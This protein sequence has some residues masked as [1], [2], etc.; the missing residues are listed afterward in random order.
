MFFRTSRPRITWHPE[1]ELQFT[2]CN[3][4]FKFPFISH[5]FDKKTNNV[6]KATTV[7]CKLFNCCLSLTSRF[8]CIL[9]LHAVLC[10]PSMCVKSYTNL[11]IISMQ[12][13]RWFTPFQTFCGRITRF[14][15]FTLLDNFPL[16]TFNWLFYAR[17]A[18]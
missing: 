12:Y 11:R 5:S 14:H 2:D 18:L 10:V 4:T 6:Y 13:F 16:I 1:E 3:I 17:A 9:K 15:C 8:H 7:T